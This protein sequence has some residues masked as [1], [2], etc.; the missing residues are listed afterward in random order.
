MPAFARLGGRGFCAT[1]LVMRV[2][3]VRAA[4]VC[5]LGAVRMGELVIMSQG[6]VSVHL[7]CKEIIVKMVVHQASSGK[8]ATNTAYSGAPRATA[9]GCS[10]SASAG[11]AGLVPRATCHVRPSPGVATACSSVTVSATTPKDAT[12]RQAGASARLD[13]AVSV[14]NMSVLMAAMEKV[15]D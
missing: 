11:R 2:P 1:S 8:D 7:V 10:A 13:T 3:M 6:S 5:A 4:T 15:A 12:Q 9:T 14:A